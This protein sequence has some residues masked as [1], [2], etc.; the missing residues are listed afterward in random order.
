MK[1]RMYEQ[2]MKIVSGSIWVCASFDCMCGQRR[3]AVTPYTYQDSDNGLAFGS[4][5]KHN[6]IAGS[7]YN[8][9]KGFGE[10]L[11]KKE[12]L[13]ET[14]DTTKKTAKG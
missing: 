6:S 2:G 1:Y 4:T 14:Y 10:P 11:T 3:K 5:K 9:L 7:P 13:T 8:Y 12:R